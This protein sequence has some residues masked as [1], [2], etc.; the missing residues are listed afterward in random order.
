MRYETLIYQKA[1][2]WEKGWPASFWNQE[3]AMPIIGGY[4]LTNVACSDGLNLQSCEMGMR[5]ILVLL[6]LP[7]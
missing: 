6:L 5:W 2:S 1:W 7:F 3:L 4:G